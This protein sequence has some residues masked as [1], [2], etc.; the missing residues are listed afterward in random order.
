MVR[1]FNVSLPG[2][3]VVLAMSD[4]FA[5][6]SALLG[7]AFV[8]GRAGVV[9]P[10]LGTGLVQIAMITLIWMPCI[11]YYDLYETSVL[12][13][14]SEGMKRLL[15]VTGT[16]CLALGFLYLVFPRLGMPHT[17]LLMWVFL[18][19]L[20]LGVVR[21]VFSVVSRSGSLSQRVILFGSGP[22]AHQLYEQI[23]IRPELGLRVVGSVGISGG[24]FG[25][26][27]LGEVE[28]L[29]EVVQR[30]GAKHVVLTMADRRGVMP[31]DALFALKAG[32]VRI[33]DGVNLYEE[34]TGKL[35]LE[36]LRP[37]TLLFSR[38]FRGS[39]IGSLLGRAYEF[40]LASIMLVLLSPIIAL[41][42]L[43][44][45]LDSPGPVFFRQKRVGKNSKVFVLYKLRSMYWDETDRSGTVPAG[46]QDRRITRVGYWLR[47]FRL[48]ELPQ[49]YNIAKGDMA[50]IGPRP[51]TCEMEADLSEKIAFYRQRWAVRP[52]A[53]GWAQVHGGYCVTLQ[54]NIEKLS[55]DLYYI[56]NK[57]FG[58]DCLVLLKTFKILLLGKER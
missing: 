33:L 11:Y 46:A 37:S 23:R 54:D 3:T 41:M 51:F 14:I 36:T 5:I 34:I 28:D 13:S 57:S 21:W 12:S 10:S 56:K 53:T 47:R 52:G 26:P 58:L 9:S 8:C 43:A 44:I 17:L 6:T 16:A 20:T 39:F 31:I 15:Q 4:I 49:L 35:H 55:H 42:A 48:D 50:F 40:T 18:A 1:V 2:R 22:L 30:E 32:G 38:G 45:R 27:N 19:G 29:A 25:I 24:T 7:A